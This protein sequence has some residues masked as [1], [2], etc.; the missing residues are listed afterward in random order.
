M[1]INPMQY[2]AAVAALK[3]NTTEQRQ[4]PENDD[5]TVKRMRPIDPIIGEAQNKMMAMPDVEIDRV[6]E[7][8]EAISNGKISID[9]DALTLAMQKHYQR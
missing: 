7:M 6:L 8:K 1:K 5:L 3:T 4:L 9:L 2:S